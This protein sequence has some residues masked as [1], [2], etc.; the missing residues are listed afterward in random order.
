MPRDSYHEVYAEAMFPSLTSQ[1]YS[2]ITE[3]RS[4]F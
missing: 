4:Y 2:Q 3:T 1:C